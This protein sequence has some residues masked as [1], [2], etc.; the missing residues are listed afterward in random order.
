MNQPVLVDYESMS[1][2]QLRKELKIRV[3]KYQLRLRSNSDEERSTS[4]GPNPTGVSRMSKKELISVLKQKPALGKHEYG[5]LRSL[6]LGLLDYESAP[7]NRKR[8]FSSFS[9]SCSYCNL[10]HLSRFLRQSFMVA[11]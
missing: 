8:K 7:D 5:T 4:P 3:E 1:L 9:I 10:T 6:H 2:T 11:L